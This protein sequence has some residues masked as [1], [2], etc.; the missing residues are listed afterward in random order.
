[1]LIEQYTLRMILMSWRK[2]LFFVLESRGKA[3]FVTQHHNY[4]ALSPWLYESQN[5]RMLN[6]KLREILYEMY[7]RCFMASTDGLLKSEKTE[8]V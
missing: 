2:K 3:I 8:M 6:S 1:M 4:K 7:F 5:L